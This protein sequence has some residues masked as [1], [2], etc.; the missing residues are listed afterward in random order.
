MSK[1][2]RKSYPSA[3]SARQLIANCAPKG[4]VLVLLANQDRNTWLSFRNFPQVRTCVATDVNAYDLL[5]HKWILAEEGA[6][7]EVA[8]RFPSPAEEAES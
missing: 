4:T 1:A 7:E 5:A 2:S 6:L 8:K 3:K